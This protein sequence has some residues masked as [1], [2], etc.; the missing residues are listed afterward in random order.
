M[1]D[2]RP[3]DTEFRLRLLRS[4][5]PLASILVLVAIGLITRASLLQ[6]DESTRLQRRAYQTTE[7]AQTL[8]G[9]L[10]DSQRGMRGYIL[11]GRVE[12]LQLYRKAV[13]D[14]PAELSAL[15]RLMQEDAGNHTLSRE[16]D[17][18]I[19]AV[20]TYSSRLLDAHDQLGIEGAARLEMS[21]AGMAVMDH[22]RSALQSVTA[23][24]RTDLE[25]HIQVAN[26]DLA[27]TKRLVSIGA[28]MALGLLLFANIMAGREARL[29][30]SA[31]LSLQLS[32]QRFRFLVD[33]V[34]DY[35]LLML[36][37]SGTVLS[38]N[39]GAQRMYGYTSEE[40]IGKNF[41]CFYPTEACDAQHPQRELH[42][43]AE[44]DRYEEEGL[45]VRKD[46]TQFLANAVISA[47][48]DENSGLRGFAKVTRNI[49]EM[50][51]RDQ[52]IEEQAQILDL[53]N[54]TI[55]VRDVNDRITYW[56][57]GAQRVYGWTK[58]E[59]VGRVTHTMLQTR[60][61][62]PLHEI[63][64]SV[65]STGHWEG[66]LEHARK[67][68]TPLT[69]ASRWT[70]QRDESGA[71]KGIIEM[72]YDVTDRKRIAQVLQ[73]KNDELLQASRAKDTFLAN[74]SHELRTP[75]NGIIGF[76][77]ILADELP[78]PVNAKQKEY[79]GDILSSGRHLL[80]L[81]NDLLDLAKVGAGKMDFYPEAFAVQGAVEEA[82]Q[83]V[84][85]GADRKQITLLTTSASEIFVVCLDRQRFKQILLNL[86]SNAVKFTRDRG[87]VEVSTAPL[88]PDRFS[89]SV[90]DTGI[91]IAPEDI[92]RI[93][94]EFE[95]L[96]S[97][98]G[99]MYQG[100]GLGLALTR[101]LVSM[102][103]GTISVTSEVGRGTTF[104]VVLPVES[105]KAK[106]AG[107]QPQ[108]QAA[109]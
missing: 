97:G 25:H 93:F 36:D 65:T 50:R 79:L 83:V 58:Q 35:A 53:A 70:L 90:R 107:A 34:Q 85:P 96:D 64:E 21:G 81:I 59:A 44:E 105:A 75:L 52:A 5:P 54:D 55:F 108:A 60:F 57:Q 91:G 100:T 13:A 23:S 82:C 71:M 9:S 45:R 10:T 43:A 7:T 92:Q 8:L 67:D 84:R 104:T 80:Q 33:G 24:A 63:L 31:S 6:L 101:K 62:R 73:Q 69:V 68:G 15:R 109:L 87:T 48:Y 89:L 77:E 56:N 47:I 49:T 29:S 88:D 42:I 12:A 30:R 40:I 94:K 61:P 99:R 16:L 27:R 28:L 20:L 66:E 1:T 86:L 41:S 38:W 46:G 98:A 2:N 72:N 95:Q 51:R 11:S 4:L 22:A 106:S 78:G 74:M 39:T 17:D 19:N 76:S 32:E 37:E 26:G 3:M 18:T 103:G 14:I 102:Q